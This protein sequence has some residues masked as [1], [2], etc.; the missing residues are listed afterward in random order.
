ML[1]SCI[2]QTMSAQT[3]RVPVVDFN[4]Q[5][6]ERDLKLSDLV[7]SSEYIR[8]ETPEDALIKIPTTLTINDKL[9]IVADNLQK[10][11]FTFDREGKY[12]YKVD[13][14][15][16]GPEEYSY[17]TASCV[18]PERKEAYIWD[19]SSA[20]RIMVYS[21]DGT[22]KRA[23]SIKD[24]C[25]P[26]EMINYDN[27]NL[28]IFAEDHPN[29]YLLADKRTG[30][31]SKLNIRK[32][33]TEVTNADRKENSVYVVA[34]NR[35]ITTG[36]T[37]VISDLGMET[38]YEAKG[39]K[40]VPMFNRKGIGTNSNGNLSVVS[41][42]IGDYVLIEVIPKRINKSSGE[43]EIMGDEAYT[44]CLNRKTLEIF[45]VGDIDIEIYDGCSEANYLP[46]KTIA[47]S[48]SPFILEIRKE[49]GSL[50]E[51]LAKVYSEMEPDDNPLIEITTFK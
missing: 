45:K 22:F 2:W 37:P 6:P 7:K 31:L 4:K 1:L 48:F 17:I 23:M 28:L 26:S 51:K 42:V 38:V 3:T 44:L 20:Q 30:S 50:N 49:K 12:L 33:N 8:L 46:A 24:K 14:S 41:N 15:G 36:N 21:L 19:K 29:R 9:I 39:G 10:Q 5:Y 35:L 34:L 11:I 16:G 18:D 32:E 40:L 27:E 47:C 25:R 13:R 43:T